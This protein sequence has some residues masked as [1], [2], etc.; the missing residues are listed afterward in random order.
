MAVCETNGNILYILNVLKKYTDED[1]ILSRTQICKKIKEIYGTNIERQTFYRDINLLIEKFGFDIST[2][3]D[4]GRGYYI[5]RDPETEFEIG[6]ILAIIEQFSYASYIPEFISNEI[7][8]KCKNMLNVYEQ[9]KL[10]DYKII[11]SN[12]KTDNL[13]IIKNVEDIENA[14]YNNKKIKFNYIKYELSKSLEKN[15]NHEI[16]CSPYQLVYNLQQ[17]YL[18]CLKDNAKV[19]YTYRL[20]KIKDI[21]ILNEEAVKVK[22]EKIEN[23]I[24]SNVSMFSG[25][26]I[27]IEFS[28]SID[29]L[30]MIIDQF[31]V[32]TTLNIIDENTFKAKVNASRK[33]FKYFALRNI[34]SVNVISPLSLKE[35]IK[36]IIKSYLEKN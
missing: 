13:E 26:D 25:D 30:N 28:C 5:L 11:S 4:N 19:L 22:E 29:L 16:I 23:Y 1:H 32:N 36:D 20:D 31:G 15:T 33:G 9:E 18:V 8:L 12:K 17:L 35:E 27:D 10:K 21:E 7:I 3:N 2:Y 6:E 24:K 34:E 14:I